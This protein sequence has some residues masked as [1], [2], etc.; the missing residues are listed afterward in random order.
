MYRNQFIELK[1]DN[2]KPYPTHRYNIT[3]EQKNDFHLRMLQLRN[4][5]MNTLYIHT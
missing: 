3:Y 4:D 1:H 2:I 5:C